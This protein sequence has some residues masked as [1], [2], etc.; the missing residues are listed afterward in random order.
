[1]SEDWAELI[2][3]WFREV[4]GAG[5]I[6]PDGWFGRPYDNIFHLTSRAVRAQ[7]LIME[8][9]ALILLIIRMPAT[10]R[11]EGECLTISGFP[12]CIFAWKEHGGEAWHLETYEGGEVTFWA[13]PGQSRGRDSFVEET[14]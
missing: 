11:W 5:L 9:D 1:M 13:V 8:L 14:R 2:L 6:L 10:V 4:R 7:W 3:G 12:L